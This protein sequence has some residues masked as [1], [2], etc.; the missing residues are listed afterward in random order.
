MSNK[1]FFVLGIS[2]SGKSYAAKFLLLQHM[3]SDSA[4]VYVLDPNAEYSCLVRKLGGTE[5]TLSKD[6]EKII[7]LFIGGLDSHH[8]AI[9]N[10]VNF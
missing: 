4:K 5:I 1:H 9:T 8:I 10:F 6:S 3:L 7:N 2:G